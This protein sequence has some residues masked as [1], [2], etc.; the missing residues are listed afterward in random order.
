MK[1][2]V[3][4]GFI[5]A[6]SVTLLFGN[7]QGVFASSDEL[8]VQEK[9]ALYKLDLVQD[10]LDDGDNEITYYWKDESGV[11][12]HV[13]LIVTAES[14]AGTISSVEEKNIIS[15]TQ[16]DVIQE[17]IEQKDARIS[18]MR[19]DDIFYSG[20]ADE[21]AKSMKL[22]AVELADTT[23]DITIMGYDEV[24]YKLNGGSTRSQFAN[25]HSYKR[26]SF[27]RSDVSTCSRTR[28]DKD[29][30]VNSLRLN[31]VKHYDEKISK[32]Q[33]DNSWAIYFNKRF[34]H[35]ISQMTSPDYVNTRW[36]RVTKVD[37]VEETHHP[38]C[39]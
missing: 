24:A 31:T 26:H 6:L 37:G 33:G 15:S 23:G 39:K 35:G 25:D 4:L 34:A 10:V 22:A 19:V 30:G 18:S 11:E 17:S 27:L 20:P 28:Y 16:L 7:I 3:S 14:D 21:V 9:T 12:Q 36:H 2:K 29:V 8:D 5:A 1:K 13:D 38:L 32:K